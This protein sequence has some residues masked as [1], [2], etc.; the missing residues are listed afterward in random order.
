LTQ[1]GLRQVP[2]TANKMRCNVKTDLKR[3][4]KTQR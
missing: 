1:Y 3:D 2:A 4:I